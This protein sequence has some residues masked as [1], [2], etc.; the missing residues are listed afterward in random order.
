MKINLGCGFN[1]IEGFINCDSNKRCDPDKV[2]DLVKVK[3]PFKDNEVEEVVANYFF[4]TLGDNFLPMMKEIYRVCN[5]GAL[6]T[7]TFHHPRN[8]AFFAN[9]RNIRPLSLDGFR[10]FGKKYAQWYEE[11]Q[12]GALSVALDLDVDFEIVDFKF[13]IEPEYEAALKENAMQM[14]ALS[15]RFANVQSQVGIKLMVIKE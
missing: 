9:P 8:D 7:I 6:V 3:L 15:K 4:E 13:G 5:N 2:I 11:T 10:H 12:N 14:E 1:K